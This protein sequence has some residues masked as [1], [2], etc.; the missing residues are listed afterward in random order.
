MKRR[1]FTLVEL[2]IV[3]AI[4]GAL[5]SL[6]TLS[7]TNATASANATKIINNLQTMKSAALMF[8]SDYKDSSDADLTKAD[9]EG[10]SNDYFDVA[11]LKELRKSYGLDMTTASG[12]DPSKWY[13]GYVFAEDAAAD[14]AMIKK[15]LKARAANAGLWGTSDTA[16]TAPSSE[17]EF[18]TTHTA[19]YIRVR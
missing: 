17:T 15:L 1:G 11:T 9:F 18:T 14:D 8:Y 12:N 3:I 13:V 16:I 6:M 7:G 19:V 4:L 10:V 5:A 2:L